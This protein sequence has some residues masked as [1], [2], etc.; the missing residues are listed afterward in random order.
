M[1]ISCLSGS[2]FHPCFLVDFAIPFSWTVFQV[3][4]LNVKMFNVNIF[5]FQGFMWKRSMRTFG[6]ELRVKCGKAPSATAARLST[7]T[8]I[9]IITI[10]MIMVILL[11]SLVSPAF[12]HVFPRGKGAV[13]NGCETID[14]N[15]HLI[16]YIRSDFILSIWSYTFDLTLYFRSDSRRRLQRLR[17]DRRQLQGHGDGPRARPQPGPEW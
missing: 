9:M 3:K 6:T 17:D 11:P 1:L 7:T 16:V 4:M 12:F 10:M 13:C 15:F 14:D 8:S 2:L 5:I